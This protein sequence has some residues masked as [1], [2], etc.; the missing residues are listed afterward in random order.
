MT[1]VADMF[2][3]GL[4]TGAWVLGFMAVMG[5][6]VMLVSLF[7]CLVKAIAELDKRGE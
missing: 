4:A 5:V 6:G 1:M 7:G 2:E 3:R